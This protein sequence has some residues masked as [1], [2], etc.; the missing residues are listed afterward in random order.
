MQKFREI[1][2]LI[3][4]H[5]PQ[6]FREN[7]ETVSSSKIKKCTAYVKYLF[8]ENNGSFAFKKR[9]EVNFRSILFMYIS[10][11]LVEVKI[12]WRFVYFYST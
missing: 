10:T 12:F 6:K 2:D 8:C 5:C 11:C 3:M 7:I 9:S 4:L 1:N